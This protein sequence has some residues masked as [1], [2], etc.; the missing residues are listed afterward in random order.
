MASQPCASF[1]S[2][3]AG[4]LVHTV[5]NP[6]LFPLSVMVPLAHKR[7]RIQAAWTQTPRARGGPTRCFR[8][9]DPSIAVFLE[10]A[11]LN[12]CVRMS[13]L[14]RAM[15]GFSVVAR[16]EGQFGLCGA[17]PWPVRALVAHDFTSI[18]RPRWRPSSRPCGLQSLWHHGRQSVRVVAFVF[19]GA[20]RFPARVDRPGRSALGLRP[21]RGHCA[22]G[23]HGGSDHTT[24]YVGLAIGGA[25]RVQ[26]ELWVWRRFVG[27]PSRNR[28]CCGPWLRVWRQ[29]CLC[30]RHSCS[31]PCSHLG[32]ETMA[33]KRHKHLDPTRVLNWIAAS[34]RVML[35]ARR[36]QVG[37][38][39]VISRSRVLYPRHGYDT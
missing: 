1:A 5:C 3:A 8:Q 4:T 25:M 28:P 15:L 35:R 31:A 21:V 6:S 14:D 16:T 26:A 2:H 30:C 7:A 38:T 18:V 9:R 13:S 37:H 34:H 10:R 29:H 20:R 12:K 19:W 17:A 33:N 32:L 23:C 22:G 27:C 39:Q 36:G 11:H 24:C